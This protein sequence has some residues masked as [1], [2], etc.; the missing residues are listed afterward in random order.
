MWAAGIG[1]MGQGG[2]RADIEVLKRKGGMFQ[3][4][5]L[6]E[7]LEEVPNGGMI[8][9]EIEKKLAENYCRK[10]DTEAQ[11][12]EMEALRGEKEE[13]EELL[14]KATEELESQKEEQAASKREA[15][16]EIYSLHEKLRKERLEAEIEKEIIRNGGKNTKAVMALL[17]MEKIFLGEDGKPAGLNLEDLKKTDGYL[18]Y[19]EQTSTAGTGLNREPHRSENTVARQFEKALFHR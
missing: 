18:F 9:E 13:L 4:D 10:E 16:E 5:W 14:Q 6:N 2:I 1:K 19:Q 17:D 3:M 12:G 7:L 8:A 15:A 11:R